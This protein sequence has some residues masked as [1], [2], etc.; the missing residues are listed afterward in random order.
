[1]ALPAAAGLDLPQLTQRL[2]ESLLLGAGPAP[3]APDG[4]LKE[5]L[6]SYADGYIDG[7][8]STEAA[9]GTV[10]AAALAFDACA[11]LIMPP[12]TRLLG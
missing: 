6:T 4:A 9:L 5:A 3:S 1:M 11:S 12:A 7:R 2:Q 8:C 10:R